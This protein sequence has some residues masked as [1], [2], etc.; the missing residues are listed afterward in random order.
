MVSKGV[1]LGCMLPHRVLNCSVQRQ[2]HDNGS[3]TS[4]ACCTIEIANFY[5]TQMLEKKIYLQSYCFN[6]SIDSVMTYPKLQWNQHVLFLPPAMKHSDGCICARVL[7]SVF[8][9]ND[10]HLSNP[11][12]LD[13]LDR[14]TSSAT[15]LPEFFALYFAG[16]RSFKIK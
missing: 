3:Q 12:P 15:Y 13:G 5:E 11:T 4:N 9:P 16:R 14:C 10:A 8:P 1:C 7:I 2:K 6:S